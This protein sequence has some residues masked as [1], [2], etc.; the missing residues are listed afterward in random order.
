MRQDIFL[1][2]RG[3]EDCSI[4][5]GPLRCLIDGDDN[6][7]EPPKY[8]ECKKGRCRYSLVYTSEYKGRN[9]GDVRKEIERFLDRSRGFYENIKYYLIPSGNPE[10]LILDTNGTMLSF[11][12]GP[13]FDPYGKQIGNLE[14]DI[15]RGPSTERILWNLKYYPNYGYEVRS[16]LFK[17]VLNEKVF[18]EIEQIYVATD[19][20]IAGAFI[21]HSLLRKSEKEGNSIDYSKVK[22]IKIESMSEKGVM[23]AFNNPLEFDWGNAYAGKLRA[24]FDYFFGSIATY[25]LN[26]Q[27]RKI[28]EKNK[29][30]NHCRRIPT[31]GVGRVQIPALSLIVK[32]EQKFASESWTYFLYI[33]CHNFE[34]LGCRNTKELIHQLENRKAACFRVVFKH[35]L[36]TESDFIKILGEHHVGTHTTRSVQIPKLGN[37]K[38]IRIQE[39][40]ITPTK[41]GNAYLRIIGDELK[42]EEFDPASIEFNSG[43]NAILE[44]LKRSGKEAED[45][46]YLLLSRYL[47]VIRQLLHKLDLRY[48]DIAQ[49]LAPHVIDQVSEGEREEGEVKGLGRPAEKGIDLR[50]Q[51][52]M[53][54]AIPH[55][56][57]FEI[58]EC[59][60]ELLHPLLIA[61]HNL[62]QVVF[63]TQLDHSEAEEELDVLIKNIIEDHHKRVRNGELE[64]TVV[65]GITEEE[66]SKYSDDLAHEPL[67]VTDSVKPDIIYSPQQ[68]KLINEII[69][70]IERSWRRVD[71]ERTLLGF[72]LWDRDFERAEYYP[73][74][75]TLNYESALSLM[76]EKYGWSLKETSKMLEGLY[77]GILFKKP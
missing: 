56:T 35:S 60:P 21:A 45:R 58:L 59:Y 17:A 1:V 18:G 29:R 74:S 43:F 36:I 40:Y 63:R 19:Y 16:Y 13:I 70:S 52:R 47:D 55:G 65:S 30:L 37:K 25:K 15:K 10:Y 54:L 23:K 20:D 62:Y 28:L 6:D 31:L 41:L 38:L 49:R 2:F 42:T 34:E 44:S 3:R 33:V 7:V 53:S 76:N 67:H 72:N 69:N 11:G 71:G 14:W 27:I 68:L 4:P 22:R 8:F 61:T 46:F 5:G 12:Y 66:R 77:L 75:Q 51:I 9:L 50:D 39:G 57:Q 48:E 24:L 64:E 26:Q 32:K 73:T